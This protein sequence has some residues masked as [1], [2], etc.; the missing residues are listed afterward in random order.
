MATSKLSTKQQVESIWELG[1][2]TPLQLIKNVWKE[3]DQDNVTGRGS[4]LA[5]NYLLAIFPF[6]L[7]L[8][9]VFGL[10]AA[11]GTAADKSLVL[12]LGS[13]PACSFRTSL[14]NYRRGDQEFHQREG[15]VGHSAGIVGSVGRNDGHDFRAEWRVW[16]TRIAVMAQGPRHR[17]WTDHRDFDPCDLGAGVSAGWRS[18]CQLCRSKTPSRLGGCHWV[19]DTA[20]AGSA[21]LHR[22]GF[23][24]YLLQ[25][26][27]R[28][29]AALV[30]DHAWI[31][32]RRSVVDS[33]ILRIPRLLAFLQFLL[34][35]LWIAR[36]SDYSAG[37]VLCNWTGFPGGRRDQRGN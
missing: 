5:Y 36:G 20:M 6:L 2:L 10:F 34:E 1:G 3:I 27:E 8:L 18:H 29:G 24:R 33:C 16:R 15:D 4:E 25:R 19:E 9:A 7:F 13:A 35:H 31:G 21:F 11:R 28:E 14:E 30:L 26:S 22:A 23:F 12:F 17:C 37:L 32:G